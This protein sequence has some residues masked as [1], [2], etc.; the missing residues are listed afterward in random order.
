MKKHILA[1]ILFLTPFMSIAS[2]MAGSGV[3]IKV[4]NGEEYFDTSELIKGENQVVVSYSG[5]LTERGKRQ[6]ISS[7]PY[8]IIVDS[9][10]AKTV[11]IQLK[12]QNFKF[13][14]RSIERKE[15]LFTI[16]VAGEIVEAEQYLL[17]PRK[18]VFPYANTV[19]LVK[20]YN[21]E[22]GL[23][24]DSGKVRS[25]KDEL[26]TLQATNGDN[27]ENKGNMPS[28]KAET[29]ATLQLKIWYT[30]ATPEERASF[31]DWAQQQ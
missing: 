19:K 18:G 23:I 12:S 28:K 1:F 31:N 9:P 7:P 20:E 16:S 6:F 10:Q 2:I 21:A 5:Y 29:E 26:N 11:E 24:F 4:L 25:L 30:R 14:E 8:I 22:N 17:P 13:V 3:D 27:T 15:P